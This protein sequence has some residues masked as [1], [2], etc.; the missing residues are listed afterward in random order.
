MRKDL[1]TYSTPPPDWSL[2]NETDARLSVPSRRVAR[3]AADRLARTDHCLSGAF[4]PLVAGALA[5]MGP[6][7]AKVWGEDCMELGASRS[8]SVVR[9]HRSASFEVFRTRPKMTMTSTPDKN[10]RTRFLR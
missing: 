10:G 4:S 8:I 2:S 6:P 5:G 7:C 3:G 1:T 9:V